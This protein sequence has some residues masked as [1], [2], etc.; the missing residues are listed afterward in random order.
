MP[1]RAFD[2]FEEQA[3]WMKDRLVYGTTAY[4]AEQFDT[5]PMPGM[6]FSFV[7]SSAESVLTDRVEERLVPRLNDHMET[8]F[9]FTRAL[10]DGDEPD[11]V[12]DRFREDLLATDPLWDV[13]NGSDTV[14]EE[15]RE[16]ILAANTEACSRAAD[17]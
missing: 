7:R 1:Q 12:I 10:V 6:G 2:I 13:L 14:R 8:Q 15:A 4:L 5:F 17:W 9:A 3:E 11:D 16:D